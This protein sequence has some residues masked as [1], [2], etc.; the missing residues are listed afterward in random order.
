MSK[1]TVIYDGDCGICNALRIWVQARDT[2]EHVQFIP[3]Q[4]AD[5]AQLAPDLTPDHVR[6][7]VYAV[8]AS[9]QSCQGA[10]AIFTTLR[11]LPGLWGIVGRI[12]AVPVVSW[13]AEPVYRLIAHH[14]ATISRRLDLTQ[15]A[16]TFEEQALPPCKY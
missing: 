5:L 3:N 16:L 15:C 7:A 2:A 14:R 10:R 6:R 8:R 4:S 13:L 1:L 9:G 12:G 11:F